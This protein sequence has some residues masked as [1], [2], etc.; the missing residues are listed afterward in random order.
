[1]VKY[2][3]RR[4]QGSTPPKMNTD[5]ILLNPSYLYAPFEATALKDDPHY[6]G[7]PS[8]EF[9]YPPLGLLT[10]GGAL[11]RA[12]FDVIGIDSNTEP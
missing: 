8:D 12:G 7:L 11:K 6:L 3:C 5:V 1:M 4:L 10:I 9:L 2:A